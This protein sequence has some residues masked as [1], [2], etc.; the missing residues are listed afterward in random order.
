MSV[1]GKRMRNYKKEEGRGRKKEYFI[2]ILDLNILKISFPFT[3]Q[4]F[5]LTYLQRKMKI[6][7]I[8]NG[9]C[10]CLWGERE[11]ETQRERAHIQKM[12]VSKGTKKE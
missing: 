9:G 10:V 2:L 12:C 6:M 1:K 8:H 3:E 11:T 7:K 5:Y 4:S